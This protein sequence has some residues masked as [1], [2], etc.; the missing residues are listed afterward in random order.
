MVL[1]KRQPLEYFVEFFWTA[2]LTSFEFSAIQRS[3]PTSIPLCSTNDR[4]PLYSGLLLF[5]NR[6]WRVR[7]RRISSAANSESEC[8]TITSQMG[9]FVIVFDLQNKTYV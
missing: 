8:I 6:T 9:D 2:C 4:S 5:R 1:Q 3:Q 7:I